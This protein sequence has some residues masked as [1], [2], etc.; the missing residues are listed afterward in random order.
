MPGPLHTQIVVW[1][2]RLVSA[3]PRGR[4][5]P[6]LGGSRSGAH[7]VWLSFDTAHHHLHK[8]WW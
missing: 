3:L 5:E 2:A 4:M 1:V 6:W 8:Y 7:K